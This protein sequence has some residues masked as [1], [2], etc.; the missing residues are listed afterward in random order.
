[1]RSGR[2]DVDP[3][4][5]ELD[6]RQDVERPEPSGFAREEV[7]GDDPIRLSP[8]ELGPAR[9]GPSRSRTESGGP[10]QTPD[11]CRADAD[12]ELVQLTLDPHATPA[13]VLAGE[14]QD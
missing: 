4:A 13:R 6:E 11:R 1:M 10:D 12:A 7:A 3:P 2:T 8:E 9:S 5:P 14:T